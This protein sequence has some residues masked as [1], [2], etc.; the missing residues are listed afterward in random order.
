[1]PDPR[2]IFQVTSKPGIQRDGTTLDSPNFV[3]GQWVRFYR[4]RPRKMGGYRAIVEDLSYPTRGIFSFSKNNTNNLYLFNPKG[5]SMV[6]TDN[7]LTGTISFD[8]SP[9]S[10]A[11]S[12]LYLWQSAGIY[13]STGGGDNLVVA[14]PGKNLLDITNSAD[15]P[16]Y[17]TV[18][19]DSTSTFTTI[20]DGLGGTIDVSG[21]VCVL[22]PYVF[23]Y[24]NDGYIRN[25]NQNKPND[26]TFGAG[27]DA[28]EVNVAY[29][30]IVKG[31][32]MRGGGQ[33]PSG[34]F[35]ALDSL[36]KVTY[37]GGGAVFRYD[38]V[39][40]STVMSSEGIVEYDG[41]FFWMGVDRFY[42]YDGRVQELPNQVNINWVF[43]NLNFDQR[44]KV[45]ATVVPRWGEIW[46]H[47]PFG[48]NQTEC[49]RAVIFNVR[50]K[51]WYDT[52]IDRS[53]GVPPQV[54]RFPVWCGDTPA[55]RV[56]RTSSK[57]AAVTVTIAT[58]CVATS[59]AHGLNLN[60]AISFTTTGALPTGI[61]AGATYYVTATP[62]PDTFRF[63][64]SVGGADVNTSG[65]Q[66]GTHKVVTTTTLT[67]ANPGVFTWTS[68]NLQLNQ[69]IVL[70]TT[71]SL[72]TGLAVNTTYYVSTIPT[73]NTFTVAAAEDG[74]PIETTGSQSGTH[75]ATAI[76]AP[77]YIAYG[78]EIGYNKVENGQELAIRSYIE[79]ADFGFP[80]GGA[81]G[82]KPTG[83]DYF[84]RLIRV[85]PDFVQTGT[86]T[87]SVIGNEFAQ[88]NDPKVTTYTFDSTATK[89]DMREQRRM[90]RL[91]FESNEVN[92]FFEMGR[93]ILHTEPGDIRS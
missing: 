1:M 77:R 88:D 32:P 34:L 75:T 65:S 89:V 52:A 20:D 42:V 53:C 37:V 9:S 44:Q 3:D 25:S 79:T 48:Q 55:R 24:G 62:T 45:W 18:A 69:P 11:Y 92:G 57:Q 63:S 70:S 10:L 2:P 76:D 46:W 17:H 6:Q 86:M 73:A 35:W 4:T 90:I 7:N 43:D 12:D 33:S 50:D 21:G 26:W 85:E 72:P 56:D 8:L 80:T 47:F 41:M 23:A 49:N 78:H 81:D 36:I 68:H 15:T 40:T 54:I 14:H 71:G 30:K 19:G 93:V 39:G 38:P 91:G 66:S 22:Q 84:T 82:E 27:K 5:C 31:L 67:I 64:S 59:V 51:A 74:V 87:L 61:T 16:L 13:D 29:T 60:Q 83:N 28:N 58:P